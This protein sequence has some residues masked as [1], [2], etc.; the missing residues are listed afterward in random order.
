MNLNPGTATDF[1][2]SVS[3]EPCLLLDDGGC[4]TAISPRHRIRES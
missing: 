4:Y 2:P 3:R 1:V